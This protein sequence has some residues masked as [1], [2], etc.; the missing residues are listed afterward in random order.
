M[1]AFRA[2]YWREMGSYIRSPLAFIF[3]LMFVLLTGIFT[4]YFGNFFARGEADLNAFFAFHPYLYL[5]FMPALGMR[6]W[7]E[8][9]KSGTIELLFTLPVSPWA[10]VLGKFFAAWTFAI[11]AL[12]CTF[13][14]WL[15]VDWLGQPDHGV[16]VAGYI[17]S[18]LLGG[19]YLAISGCVSAATRNQVIAFILAAGVCFLFTATG[20]PFITGALTGWAPQSLIEIITG[21]SAL[22]HFQGLVKGV[23]DARDLVYFLS[24]IGLWLIA[25]VVTLNLVRSTS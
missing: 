2:I 5:F 12:A 10:A 21:L 7:A 9:R 11:L 24:L 18:M 6:L 19:G 22:T 13:P 1:T 25:S 3:V 16:I 14:M 15:S 23:L 4:F 8:E 20:M 17:G